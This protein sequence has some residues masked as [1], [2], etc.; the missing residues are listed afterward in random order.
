M[1]FLTY[2]EGKNNTIKIP[3]LKKGVP[4]KLLIVHSATMQQYLF[5]IP[6]YTEESGQVVFN[7][8]FKSI[9]FSGQYNYTLFSKGKKIADGLLNISAPKVEEQPVNDFYFDNETVLPKATGVTEADVWRILEEA[10]DSG[11]DAWI[12]TRAEYE[13]LSDKDPNTWYYITD[14]KLDFNDLNNLPTIKIKLNGQTS[15]Y[16]LSGQNDSMHWTLDLDRLNIKDHETPL[17]WDEYNI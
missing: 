9:P 6:T 5:P 7:I 2:R 14:D 4:D 11:M 1:I 10:R 8:E 13:N 17:E 12:G 16:T 15:E 3:V